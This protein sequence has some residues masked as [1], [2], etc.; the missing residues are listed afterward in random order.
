MS[1][2]L[3]VR[4]GGYLLEVPVSYDYADGSVGYDQRTFSL[5]PRGREIDLEASYRL[6]LFRGAGSLSGHGFFRR[7]PGHVEAAGNDIGA[8]VRVNLGF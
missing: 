2:P 4:S 1:Q 7:Q 6:P 5:A 8:A 3:R